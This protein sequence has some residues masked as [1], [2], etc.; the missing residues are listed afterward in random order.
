MPR[1]RDFHVAVFYCALPCIYFALYKCTHNL[2][3]A[4]GYAVGAV[5][6]WFCMI[7]LKLSVMVGPTN[8]KKRFWWWFGPAYGFQ[9]TFPLPSP[10]AIVEYGILVILG[11]LLAFLIIRRP[12]FTTL[13]EMA[14]ADKV[15]NPQYFKSDLA[16]IQIR[17]WINPEI[18]IQSWITFGDRR[19]GGGLRSE[20]SHYCYYYVNRVK[21][22]V[23]C[24]AGTRK[25]RRVNCLQW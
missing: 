14:Y 17:I 19:L 10:I 16:Y 21:R 13:G 12:S 4:R 18:R 23:S 15:M 7:W 11:D 24:I 8:R 9:I 6:Q 2:R 3:Q 25:Q 5:C 22:S 1:Y 20:H